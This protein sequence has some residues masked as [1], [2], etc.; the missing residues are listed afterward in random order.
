MLLHPL[1]PTGLENHL[2]S[3]QPLLLL[4]RAVRAAS[5]SVT[6]GPTLSFHF[7]LMPPTETATRFRR[8]RLTFCCRG[9]ITLAHRRRL[10][11]SDS[12]RLG[13]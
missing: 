9:K 2:A 4:V 7:M 13:I 10:C 6:C 3:L 11:D 8:S 1:N 5:A 12:T